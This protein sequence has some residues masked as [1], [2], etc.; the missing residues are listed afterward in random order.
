M[1]FTFLKFEIKSW[2]RAPMPWIFMLIFALLTFGA[3]VSDQI[4]IGGSFGNIWKNA[5]YV[6]QNWY[7]VFSILSLL[8]ITAFLNTAAIRDFENNTAQIVFSSPVQ[9]AGYFFGHFFG[10]LLICLLPMLGVSL[11]MWIGVAINSLTHWVDLER[12]GPFEIQGHINAYLAFVIP[13]MIFAGSILFTV[14]ALTRSTMYSFISAMVLLVGYIVAGNLMRDI[15]NERFAALLD[16]FG[17]RPFELITKYWTVDDKNHQSVSLFH[18]MLLVNRLLWMGTGLL[19]LVLGYFRFDFSEKAKKVGKKGANQTEMEPYGLRQLG[20]LHNVRPVAGWATT[21]AQFRSQ[22]KA[23]FWGVIKST[24]FI[25]LSFIGLL[26]TIPSMQFATEAYGTHNLPVTYTMVDIIRGAFYMFL[27]AI[28]AYFTGALVWKERNAKVNEIYDAMP[29]RNW[30][31]FLSKFLTIQGIAVVLMSV[32]ILAAIVAQALH[33]YTRFDLGV[34]VRELLLLDLLGFAFISVLFLL[35]HTLSPNMY[36][37]FFICIVV[38]ILNSFI[39]GV[40]RIETNMVQFGATPGYTIS[41]L[42]GYKP[43]ARG[44]IGFNT[45]WALF[46]AILAVAAI[47]LW[48]RGKETGWRKRFKIAGMEWRSYRWVGFGAIA[49]WALSAAWVFYNTLVLN[50]FRNSKQ[51]EKLTVRY[52]K[53]YKRF[54]GK[55]QPRIYDLKYDIQIFPER[56]SIDA[57]GQMWVRNLHP[58][59]IDTLLVQVPQRVKFELKNQRLK[60]LK[61]DKDLYFRIYRLQ[62]ALQPGDSLRLDFS[63]VYKN[64]GFENEL[65]VQQVMQN[66]TFFNN[67]DIAPRLG[68]QPDGEMTDKNRR[69]K[70]KLPEKTRAPKLNR[71]DTLARGNSYLGN[72]ANWV[73]V[74]TVISTAADQIAIAPGS[75]QKEW[76]EN[77]R[78]YFRYKLDH[79]SFNF[80]SFMSAR[81]EVARKKWKGIDLEV[82]YH[83]D[84]A[85]NVERMLKSMEKSLEYYTTNFGP[86]FHKQ[87]RIIEF[88]RYAELAQAFPGTMPYSE[89]I[90]FIEDFRAEKDDIDMV[91]YIV[92]HEMGHQWWAHQECG[93]YMQGSEMTVETFAQ[94]SAL[95]VMEKEYG[96]D[97]M[98]KF[99]EYEADR[100][101]RGRGAERLQELPL[102]KCENQGYIHY[103]KGSLVMYYL[104]EM[105]GEERVNQALRDFLNKFRYAPPPFPVSSDVV[106]EFARQTPDSLQYIIQDLFWDITLF[107]NRTTDLKVKELGK[108]RYEVTLEVESRKLKADALGKEKE[109]KVADWI[110][111]GAFAKPEKGKKY[112][113]TLYRQRV[114]VNRAKN[115]FSFVVQGKPDKAGIDPFTLLVDRN[116]EDNLRE[117]E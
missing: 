10:A 94:Y 116:P 49:L 45:Y 92:A 90:G 11:G 83:K 39:W 3:T 9:K 33:G 52:E 5:P 111:I 32:C 58:Q 54:E 56:R 63:S 95:M 59:A 69:K 8:L 1:F 76:T 62:P 24:P 22:L 80:Y 4:S 85:D 99:L 19:V 61:E 84:H 17:F 36:L 114:F 73:N 27:V 7:G 35:I 13:N 88:P 106:D 66:G 108:D 60:L 107:E 115:T 70:Y 31:D 25:L 55:A 57:K 15:E 109:V 41:D 65:S 6:A 38:V 51:Q 14:A 47:C 79:Y 37:G 77:G 81:Y 16:P 96:R 12:F 82:Y 89:G 46:S 98:R 44:L 29:T 102:A 40:L 23:N 74:E 105:I 68:Y 93:A 91:F 53:D 34:Y 72:D 110:E 67:F 100:Y 87:C 43:Y 30:T 21:L 2:L 117:W 20:A 104:K 64:K 18:P 112:G 28:V 86:Y 75:L 78:R 103:N 42:Y 48:P 50:S 26:N 101:L 97:I 113:K 71:K